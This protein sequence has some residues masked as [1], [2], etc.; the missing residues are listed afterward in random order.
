[1]SS[2]I[3]RSII[4]IV[5]LYQLLNEIKIVSSE[6]RSSNNND[7]TITFPHQS[8]PSPQL[9]SQGNDVASKQDNL[10]P[11]TYSKS[12]EKYY[13]GKSGREPPLIPTGIQSGKPMQNFG[14]RRGSPQMSAQKEPNAG[15]KNFQNMLNNIVSKQDAKMERPPGNF[16][17]FNKTVLPAKFKGFMLRNIYFIR[18]LYFY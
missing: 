8:N 10:R 16:K 15:P 12:P 9:I 18:Y 3:I 1:M 17:T 2:V 14:M 7:K 5:C 13:Q 6:Y 4:S 11:N